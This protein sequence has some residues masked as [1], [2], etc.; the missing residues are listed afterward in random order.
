M[1]EHGDDKIM[2]E[3]E[4]D[5][6][7]DCD[8]SEGADGVAPSRR[9][10][11]RMDMGREAGLWEIRRNGCSIGSIADA[12]F[13]DSLIGYDDYVRLDKCSAMVVSMIDTLVGASRPDES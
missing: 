12:L 3:D 10:T 4:Q 6:V 5:G 2:C 9:L 7:W 8:T 11:V 13:R 1:A